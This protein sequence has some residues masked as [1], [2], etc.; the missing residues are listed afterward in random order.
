MS[1]IDM[2][3]VNSCLKALFG[4]GCFSAAMAVVGLAYVFVISRRREL[5]LRWVAREAD[6]YARIGV[7]Q[8][9]I[10]V[11]RRF[12]ESGKMIFAASLGALA[13]LY[14]VPVCA[15]LSHKIRSDLQALSFYDSGRLEYVTGDNQSALR[16]FTKAIQLDP[17][18]VSSFFLRSRTKLRL[19]DHRGAVAD[20]DRVIQL[21]PHYNAG[22]YD[23]RGLAK[24]NLGDNPGA[25]ADCEVALKIDPHFASAYN[26][27]GLAEMDLTNYA[28]ALNDFNKAIEFNSKFQHAYFNRGYLKNKL[29]DFPGA[30]ADYSKAIEMDPQYSIAYFFRANTKRIL[31]DYPNA[32]ADYDKVIALS[33]HNAAA[34]SNR[35]LTLK[36]SGR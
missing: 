5:W 23:T 36:L 18:D 12:E 7:P 21:N 30:V 3:V 14:M 9:I 27:R 33:P 31:K 22:V 2:N 28:A 8:K 26:N 24:Y 32:L 19:R 4:M 20:C 10:Q 35:N 13:F 29:E 1:G 6:F 17:K 16:D 11:N 34:I 15:Y 25:I